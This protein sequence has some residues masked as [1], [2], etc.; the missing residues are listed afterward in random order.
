MASASVK[1]FGC[2]C[3]K[4]MIQFNKMELTEYFVWNLFLIYGIYFVGL[5]YNFHYF[6]LILA[7]NLQKWVLQRKASYL[8][9]I[10]SRNVIS[11]NKIQWYLCH[12]LTTLL[13]DKCFHKPQW[14]LSRIFITDSFTEFSDIYV[15]FLSHFSVTENL[16]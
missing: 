7:W 11:N 14:Y 13:C 1:S 6:S 8:L 10:T 3:K 4:Y 2:I 15:T 16:W 5:H 12:V 9:N